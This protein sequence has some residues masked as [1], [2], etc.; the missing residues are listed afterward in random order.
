V[1]WKDLP[2]ALTPTPHSPDSSGCWSGSAINWNGTPTLIYTGTQ[3]VRDEIQTQCIATSNDGLISW[4]KHPANPIISNVPE[5]SGQTRN[6]RDPYVFRDG[7]GWSVI[8]GSQIVG[9]G[10]T[11]FLYHSKDFINWEFV[12]P[13]LTGIEAE[14]GAPW[15]CPSLFPVGDRHVLV[16]SSLLPKKRLF[17][18][19]GRYVNF[20]FTTEFTGTLDYGV[21]YAPQVFA[22]S[23]GRQILFGWIEEDRPTAIQKAIGWSGAITLPRELKLDPDGRLLQ[24]FAP[25]VEQLRKRQLQLDYSD[26]PLARGTTTLEVSGRMIELYARIR[27]AQ[28]GQL[29]L[30]V[31]CH[32]QAFEYTDLIF[33]FTKQCFLVDRSHSSLDPE[34]TSSSP[35]VSLD[36]LDQ[37]HWEI[38]VFIDQSALEI[39]VSGKISLTVRAYPTLTE[40]NH[41]HLINDTD[42]NPLR[43]LSVWE[44]SSIWDYLVIQHPA[45][46]VGTD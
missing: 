25:E 40:S 18:H 7:D 12:H 43:T 30:R 10:G 44:M 3:G 41:I 19:V 4:T 34:T 23:S 8:L 22:D 46:I 21:M 2:V 39:I 1:Y 17:Y 28:H 31:L 13:L 5:I 20:S 42:E 26:K 27:P 32:P 9:Q 14:T 33:D 15:E 36:E 11:L 37:E 35:M 38:R 45:D 16:F 29:R 24:D 6:F